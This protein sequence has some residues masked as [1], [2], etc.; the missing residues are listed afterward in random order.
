M[1]RDIVA[2]IGHQLLDLMKFPVSLLCH[3]S[4]SSTATLVCCHTSGRDV[5][6]TATKGARGLL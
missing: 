6:V 3:Q 2:N 5:L 1:L 4:A